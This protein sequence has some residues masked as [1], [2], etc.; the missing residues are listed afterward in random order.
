MTGIDSK[1]L[2]A[3]ARSAAPEAFTIENVPAFFEPPSGERIIG[4]TTV[5]V[6][7]SSIAVRVTADK[8]LIVA[9]VAYGESSGAIVALDGTWRV[10]RVSDA[11]P[12]E[13]GRLFG[14]QELLVGS[15]DSG[16]VAATRL[17]FAGM[18]WDGSDVLDGR[19]VVVAPL[20]HD[21]ASHH[22]ERLSIT[23]EGNLD[24]TMIEAIDRA[25]SF[26]AGLDLELLRVDAFSAQGDLLQTRHLRGFRRV[27]R[28]PHSPFAGVADEH[29]MRAWSALVTAIPRLKK[30]GIPIIAMINH[31]GSHNAVAEI[32]TSAVL[33]LLA[34]QTAAYHRAHGHELVRGSASRRQELALL[35]RDLDLRL[36]DDDL[37]RF[38]RLRLE[39]LDGG[40]FHAPGYETG[41][42]QND[43]KFLRDIA[44]MI[45]FRLCGYSGPFYGA[46]TFAVRNTPAD[47]K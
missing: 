23:V 2:D 19:R 17:V 11:G 45:V 3:L 5:A 24:G 32:N 39:L 22:E 10:P 40:F 25:S 20:S 29:R 36:N 13:T 6:S 42:P 8:P 46:E 34:I 27:G 35:S 14:T 41:R 31:I 28:G 38:E 30:E 4:R 9:K 12:S 44:H 16:D 43:I 15:A 18:S 47:V 33:L 7:R 37:D 21:T 26:I 1:R